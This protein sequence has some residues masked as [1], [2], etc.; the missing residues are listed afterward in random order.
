MENNNY[1]NI[2]SLTHILSNRTILHVSHFCL[3]ASCRMFHYKL[4]IILFAFYSLSFST[5]LKI[6]RATV[7]VVQFA[8]N[9]DRRALVAKLSAVDMLS[10]RQI[11]RQGFHRSWVATKN[12]V[13][14]TRGSTGMCQFSWNERGIAVKNL[15]TLQTTIPRYALP[16]TRYFT[17]VLK[18][19]NVSRAN[20]DSTFAQSR[21]YRC[22][23]GQT[24]I[25]PSPQ[26]SRAQ[27]RPSLKISPSF[28]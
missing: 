15:L 8:W 20:D 23:T 2:T 9:L 26:V 11:H 12:R 7:V 5:L 3:V 16:H 17:D 19:F 27:S 14:E 18:V 24:K 25:I 10:D 28:G 6:T 13:Q 4:Q 22:L 1:Y 21:Q